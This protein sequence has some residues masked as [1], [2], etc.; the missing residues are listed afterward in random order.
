MGRIRHPSLLLPNIVRNKAGNCALLASSAPETYPATE[1]AGA[2]TGRQFSSKVARYVAA[3][4]SESED[5][6]LSRLHGSL[7]SGVA[8]S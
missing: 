6:R 1:I 5:G 7:G 4:I 2:L 3:S 8:R